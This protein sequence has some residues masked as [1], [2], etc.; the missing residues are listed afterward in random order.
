MAHYYQMPEVHY[1]A[2]YV[3]DSL[4]IS[5]RSRVVHPLPEFDLLEGISYLCGI[6]CTKILIRNGKL[7]CIY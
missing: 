2:D 6:N 7:S 4:E 5:Q 1:F 3:Q